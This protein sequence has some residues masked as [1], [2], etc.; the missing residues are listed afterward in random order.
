MGPLPTLAELRW[1]KAGALSI[2]AQIALALA[3]LCNA[4]FVIHA[5]IALMTRPTGIDESDI[6]YIRSSLIGDQGTWASQE[7]ADVAAL[8]ATAGV[9]DAYVT[10]SVPLTGAGGIAGLLVTQLG[11]SG[12]GMLFSNDVFRIVRLDGSSISIE[13]S[14][15]IAATLLAALYPTWRATCVNP[16]SQLKTR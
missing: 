13:V 7:Q 11:L 12:A 8:R 2:A 6:F 3:I 5:Q 14:L 4:M 15:A 10:N 1:N 16:A 9:V